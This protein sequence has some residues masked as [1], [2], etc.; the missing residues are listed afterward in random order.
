M[1]NGALQGAVGRLTNG[2][3]ILPDNQRLKVAY[4]H[5]INYLNMDKN[6]LFHI[7]SKLPKKA[8]GRMEHRWNIQARKKDQVTTTAASWT[9]AANGTFTVSTGLTGDAHLFAVGDVVIFP[10]I[11]I[12]EQIFVTTV[13]QSTGVVTA[14]TVSG[15]PVTLTGGGGDVCFLVSNSFESGSG[16]GTIKTEQPADDYNYVQ[17][18]QTPIGITTTAKQ[19]DYESD[20]EWDKQR[21]EAGVDHAFK[22]EKALFFGQ[23]ARKNTGINTNSAMPGVYEQWFMGGL[24]DFIS[25]NAVDAGGALTQTEFSDWLIPSTKYA[26][27][28]MI[29]S[30]EIVYE[31]L[32][33]WAQ[34]K[35]E[36]VSQ[37]E[38]SLGMSVT[39][40]L[41]PYGDTVMLMP[42]REL[43]IDNLN[44]MAF[45]VDCSDVEYRFLKGLDT[46]V[47]T[48]LQGNDE[49]LKIDEFRTWASMKVGDERRHGLLYNVSSITA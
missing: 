24:Y 19:L 49:K 32:T 40:Y 14:E 20:P 12:T 44:T 23:R 15:N 48:D 10:S 29:F 18:I 7:M 25:T 1:S 41:T 16:K 34:T 38:S 3:N 5:K 8:V 45:C 43:L 46:H 9:A 4:D 39:K 6:I 21:F 47:D 11:S 37:K 36:I 17:I 30:S 31:A 33:T 22:I 2:N 13:N 42:H 28:P 35:L 27:K 26:K